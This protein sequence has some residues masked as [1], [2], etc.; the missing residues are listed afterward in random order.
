MS[1]SR[2]PHCKAI[3]WDRAPRLREIRDFLVKKRGYV[4]STDIAIKFGLRP[5]NASNAVKTLEDS[6]LVKIRIQSHP[7]GGRMKYIRWIG[8]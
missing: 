2:C 6:G 5:S 8:E 3:L 7:T 4:S 1:L